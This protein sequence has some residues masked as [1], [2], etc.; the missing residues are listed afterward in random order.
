MAPQDERGEH[1]MAALAAAYDRL[2]GSDLA[3]KARGS[4]WTKLSFHCEV[5]SVRE[6]RRVY[7]VHAVR[8]RMESAPTNLDA[9]AQQS[10]LKGTTASAHDYE[11]SSGDN[12]VAWER[13]WEAECHPFDSGADLKRTLQ[14]QY[15]DAWGLTKQGALAKERSADRDGLAKGW[16]L[17]PAVP[18]AK[19]SDAEALC[20]HFLLRDY[21]LLSGDLLFAIVSNG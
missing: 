16:E 15:G 19:P 9:A 20:S 14:E 11:L 10:Q 2:M 4:V 18:R 17:L 12:I 5:Y 3:L 13:E 8:L 1:S 6:L 21:G 7:D